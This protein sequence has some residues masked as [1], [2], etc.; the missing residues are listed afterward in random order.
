MLD[1]V[2]RLGPLAER[3][4]GILVINAWIAQLTGARPRPTGLLEHAEGGRPTLDSGA[5]WSRSRS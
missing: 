1:Q 3:D 5:R 2:E 4:V